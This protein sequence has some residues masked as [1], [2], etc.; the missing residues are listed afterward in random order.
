MHAVHVGSGTRSASARRWTSLVPSWD[1]IWEPRK[2]LA[3]PASTH[4]PCRRP[5]RRQESEHP[6]AGGTSARFAACESPCRDDIRA[7]IRLVRSRVPGASRRRGH[8]PPASHV[9]VTACRTV[10]SSTRARPHLRAYRA[11][12]RLRRPNFSGLRG[13]RCLSTQRSPPYPG[14]SSMLNLLASL[15]VHQAS[16][17]VWI[18]GL[19]LLLF[20]VCIGGAVAVALMHPDPVRR[21]EARQVMRDLLGFFIRWTR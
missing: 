8:A 21:R 11:R 4:P 14:E 1:P 16:V 2:S 15:I 17:V 12:S 9:L 19:P 20:A 18:V 10:P 3:P 5:A 13:C 7:G 6:P